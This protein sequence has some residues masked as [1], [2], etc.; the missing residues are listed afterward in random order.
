M[1]PLTDD[2]VKMAVEITKAAVPMSSGSFISTPD[3]VAKFIETVAK[4][5]H[6]LKM[7]QDA[8]RY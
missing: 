4:K 8:S 1:P 7:S 3:T 5:I 6:E 2:S